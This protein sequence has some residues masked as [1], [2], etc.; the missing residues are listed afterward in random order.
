LLSEEGTTYGDPL[1]MPMYVH[2]YALG[3]VPLVNALSDDR[4]K[5]VWYA[6]DATVCGQLMDVH[7]WWDRL[8]SIGPDFGY[9]SN[10]SETCLIV[11]DSFG[12][13][14][15]IYQGSG[16]CISIDSK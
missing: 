15:S 6:D 13:A 7:H 11:K 8:V 4:M 2:N 12:L 10:P 3:I 16:V 1:A 9:F 5:Q 14:V